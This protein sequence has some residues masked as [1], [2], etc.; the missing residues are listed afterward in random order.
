[1]ALRTSLVVLATT[2]GY[3]L[4]N[5]GLSSL[6]APHLSHL[7]EVERRVV[8]NKVLSSLNALLSTCGSIYVCFV[9]PPVQEAPQIDERISS[10]GPSSWLGIQLAMELVSSLALPLFLSFSSP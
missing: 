4:L 2:T 6:L 5:V 3:T 9:E 8:V 7:T 10:M 1:M